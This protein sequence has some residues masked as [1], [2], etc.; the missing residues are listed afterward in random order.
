MRPAKYAE[1]KKSVSQLPPSHSVAESIVVAGSGSVIEG[2]ATSP[3]R[4]QNGAPRPQPS[5]LEAKEKL[6]LEEIRRI[7]LRIHRQ[8]SGIDTPV[9]SRARANN[10]LVLLGENEAEWQ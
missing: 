8:G 9:S 6:S 1:I 5:S 10:D 3:S 7:L 2:K 4:S